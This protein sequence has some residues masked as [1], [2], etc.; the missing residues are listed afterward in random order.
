M[1]D[2]EDDKMKADDRVIHLQKIPGV[3]PSAS[4]GLVDNRLFKGGNRLHAMRAP[5]SDL[6]ILKYENGA[7][8]EPLKQKFTSFNAVLKFV[9][10]YFQ[11]RGLE[12]IRIED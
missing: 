9:T 3:D 2:I 4:S 1:I 12:V 6:W 11:K 7:L 10:T 5:N 8:P